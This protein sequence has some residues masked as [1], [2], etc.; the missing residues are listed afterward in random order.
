MVGAAAEGD[1]LSAPRTPALLA[2][3]K[4]A[5]YARVIDG[6]YRRPSGLLGRY[7]GAGMARDHRPENEWT[8]ALVD[9]QPADRILEIGFGPGVAVE[10][11]AARVTKG[12]VAGADFSRTMV[13]AAR[14]RNAAAMRAGRVDLRHGRADALPFPDAAFDKVF[15]IHTLYFWPNPEAGLREAGRVLRP[16]GRLVLTLLPREKWNASDPEAP[17][18]TPECRAYTAAEVMALCA[19]AGFVHA[20]TQADPDPRRPSSCSVVATK[21]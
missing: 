15:G 16:G 4:Q 12:L 13:A 8:V 14:R 18:G 1:G 21:A 7:I 19:A 3:L 10:L 11:V 9:P 6:Q 17:V 5:F 2:R 20:H